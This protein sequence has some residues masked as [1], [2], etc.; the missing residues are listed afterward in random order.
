MTSEQKQS[1]QPHQ[2]IEPRCSARLRQKR[3]TETS[4]AE[5]QT[6]GMTSVDA[7]DKIPDSPKSQ[8]ASESLNN[9]QTVDEQQMLADC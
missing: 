8:T 7:A 4:P 9:G 2:P 5:Q 1:D 3:L 6:S